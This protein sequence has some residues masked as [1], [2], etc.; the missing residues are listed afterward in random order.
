MLQMMLA[1]R[2]CFADA[3][4]VFSTRETAELRDNLLKI[5]VTRISAGSKT[6]PGGYSGDSTTEQFSIADTRSPAQMAQVIK[7]A[8]LEPVWKDWDV[9]FTD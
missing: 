4:L 3:G 2:L 6:N 9:A 8:N 1:L 7:D 5:C